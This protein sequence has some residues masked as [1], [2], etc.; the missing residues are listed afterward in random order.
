MGKLNME[1]DTP[2]NI[3]LAYHIFDSYLGLKITLGKSWK[4]P[5]LEISR[6]TCRP[7]IYQLNCN[8]SG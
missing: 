4:I 7:Y 5:R 1:M 3:E 6:A 2:T 8:S